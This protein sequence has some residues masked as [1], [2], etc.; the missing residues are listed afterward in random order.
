MSQVKELTPHAFWSLVKTAASAKVMQLE[1]TQYLESNSQS[2][3]QVEVSSL[4]SLVL[5]LTGCRVAIPLSL[6]CMAIDISLREVI[7]QCRDAVVSKYLVHFRHSTSQAVRGDKVSA[8]SITTTFKKARNHCGLTWAEG[9]APTFH[10]QRSLSERLYRE[11]G[12]NTQKLL[13]HK[14]QK[15]TD[16]YNDDRGKDWIIVAV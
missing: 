8:S 15:M 12:L 11:Q 14:S 13:G 5:E 2:G 6:R 10:E 16:R 7:A 4:S 1:L 3:L 9:A